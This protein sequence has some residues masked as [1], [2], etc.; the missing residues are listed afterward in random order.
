MNTDAPDRR[1]I[2]EFERGQSSGRVPVGLHRSGLDPGFKPVVHETRSPSS[3]ARFS[4]RPRPTE[5]A[6][7]HLSRTFR[8]SSTLAGLAAGLALIAY[9]EGL[10]QRHGDRAHHRS[11][12]SRRERSRV[13]AAARRAASRKP[14][15]S[16]G[17]RPR[18]PSPRRRRCEETPGRFEA[19]GQRRAG[20]DDC[21]SGSTT[22]R[23]R[24]DATFSVSARS[25]TGLQGGRNRTGPTSRVKI[26][27]R[28][29][30]YI[31]PVG[32]APAPARRTGPS[33]LPDLA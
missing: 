32:A 8:V 28:Q 12:A 4:R 18:P 5:G 1:L 23:N 20:G 31:G 26:A 24:G 7:P 13:L 2:A 29:G 21:S 6:A 3:D 30:Q 14:V 19:I 27:G 33:D 11:R 25:R 16:D 10:F 17:T 9:G 22:R 15:R